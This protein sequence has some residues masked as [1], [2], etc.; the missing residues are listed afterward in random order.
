VI[1]TGNLNQL[2]LAT[3]DVVEAGTKVSSFSAM[4]QMMVQEN[5]SIKRAE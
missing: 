4:S 1:I 5:E 3:A 2:D